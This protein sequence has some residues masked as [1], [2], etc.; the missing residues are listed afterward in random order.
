MKHRN[1]SSYRS[2]QLHLEPLEDKRLLAVVYD[3]GLAAGWQNWSWESSVDLNSSSVV[4][5]GDASISVTHDMPWAGLYLRD[6]SQSPLDSEHEVR[7]QIHGGAGNQ[8]LQVSLVDQDDEF[9]V[10]GTVTPAVGQWTEVT[11]DLDRFN[12][13]SNISGLVVQEFTGSPMGTYHID[14]IEIGDF[15]PE[16]GTDPT[17][18]PAIVVSPNIVNGQISEGIYGLNFADDELADDIDLSVNR[19]GGNSVTRFNYELDATN[20]ASD[21]FFENFPNDNANVGQLPVGNASDRFVTEN[22]QVGADTIM[23]IGTIGWT[24][25]SREIKGSFPVD[26]YGPQQQV[27]MYRPNHG[28]GVLLD[29][30]F[31]QNDPFITS[32][33]IDESFAS[34]WVEHLVTQHGS[35][36][37]GGVQYYA[38]DNEPMLWNSTH[39]DVHPE[40][41]SYDEVR[42]KGVSYATAIKQAD[43]DAQVLGPVSWGWT[44]YF[45]SALDA[46]AG[47]AWWNN[48][49]DRNAHGGEAFLPWYLSEMALAEAQTGTRLL[50]Y[51]DIHYYP[52]GEGIALTTGGGDEATQA[53]RIQSTRSLWDP[54]YV[55][56]SWINDNV[57][58]VPRMQGWID[59]NY[60]GTKLAITEYN[61]GGTEHIS[62]AV[63]QADVLG[64]FGREG[65]DLATM[66]APPDAD[67]PAGYAFRMFRNY[68]GTGLDGGKFGETSLGAETAD[69]DRVS[70]FASQRDS[71]GAVTVMLI[72]KTTEDL[73][74]PLT[75]SADYG[76]VAAE[77]Y[78]YSSEN[79]SAI[80][81]G[82]DLVLD[83]GQAEVTLPAWSVTLV[84]L[85][86]IGDVDGDFNG[87]GATNAVDIN[88]LCSQIQSGNDLATYDL[89]SDGVVNSADMDEMIL[90]VVGTFYGDANLDRFVDASDFNAWNSNKFTNSSGWELGDFNCDSSID[91]SDFNLWN[92]NK[93]QAA[94]TAVLMVDTPDLT[95]SARPQ[96][97]PSLWQTAEA[98]Q[99][100]S[101]YAV[102]QYAVTQYPFFHPA[103]SFSFER[104]DSQRVRGSDRDEELIMNDRV[105]EMFE[106]IF[107]ELDEL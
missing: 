48:P 77:V 46:A 39:R 57:M 86:S 35:A 90:N 71:D 99:S 49:Q 102:T 34:D 41:A 17:D 55:D 59:Q 81:Q 75:L 67:D 40:P 51:L 14:A 85:P 29:G 64:I 58:L 88:A 33:E 22:E 80:E 94:D 96:S 44:G 25:N 82:A 5:S 12:T 74:S 30:S 53:A 69:V 63:T 10:L 101:Q 65:V 95:E 76:D 93:F 87:D 83:D 19:W 43:P 61:F 23:T 38:L 89:T 47:G 73:V 104:T 79:L 32:N 4:H 15:I 20:L 28:N 98:S 92:A 1:L 50:D 103:E 62:G 106:T 9:I 36:S 56:D 3:D 6:T 27:N 100:Q 26:V 8:L 54:N 24:P 84:E 66:W 13:P 105:Q 97:S 60:P 31:V 52:Q 72:N 78:T 2:R 18:G 11:L 42:D 70:V 68:D 91:A 21:F 37:D 107:A 7:F 45:Y 16:D